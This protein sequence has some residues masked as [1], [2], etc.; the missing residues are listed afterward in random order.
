MVAHSLRRGAAATQ[1]QRHQRHGK[2][3][4]PRARRLYL[5]PN[6]EALLLEQLS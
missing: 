6:I 1:S 5:R 4:P 2:R 3:R